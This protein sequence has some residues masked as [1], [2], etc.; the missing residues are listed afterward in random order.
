MA[1]LKRTTGSL[2][3]RIALVQANAD[4]LR[5]RGLAHQ[6]AEDGEFDGRHITLAG[7]RVVHFG[8]CSYLGLETDVRLKVGACEAVMRWGT[9]FSSSRAYVSAPPYAE[10]ER[11]LRRM[12]GELPLVLAPTTTL[13]H[14]AAL[15]L[16]LARG[17]AVLFDVQVHSS[18]QAVLPALKQQGIPCAPVGHGRLDQVERKARALVRSH[19]RV[20][21]LCDGVYSMHGDCVDVPELFGLLD[22]VPEL[23]AYVDDAHGVGW[24]GR[25]GAGVVLGEHGIHARMAVA[26]GLAKGFAAGGAALVFADPNAARRVFSCGG[27]MVFSGPLQPAQLGAAIASAKIL[28]SPELAALQAAVRERIALFDVLAAGEGLWVRSSQPTPIRFV[29]IGDEDQTVEL[30]ARLLAAGYYANVAVYPAVPRRRAGLRMMLSARHE[31]GD[32]EGLLRALGSLR[33]GLA[34]K[35]AGAV[36]V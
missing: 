19:A 9:Q 14:Q 6:V 30:G 26:L 24:A 17:D 5:S 1:E 27:P 21:Y 29:E 7:R 12:V 20:F 35:G 4:A 33:R 16:L 18:V 10:L 8:S 28:L 3:E 2:D 15:P 34:G 22:R 32:I 31:P 23:F 13:G 25:H 11:L 36:P